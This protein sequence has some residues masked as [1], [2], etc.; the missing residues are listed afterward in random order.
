MLG[1]EPAAITEPRTA[2][3]GGRR[4]PERTPRAL[5]DEGGEEEE[6]DEID[7][8]FGGSS[9]EGTEMGA[10]RTG[11]G[12]SSVGGV[13]GAEFGVESTGF[14]A[15][16]GGAGESSPPG[17]PGSDR[18]MAGVGTGRAATAGGGAPRVIGTAEPPRGG[19]I[20]GRWPRKGGAPPR[21]GGKPPRT[22]GADIVNCQ[23]IKIK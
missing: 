4:P 9:V 16:T 11:F 7:E 22:G 10:E 5:E 20:G 13:K 3:P 12:G 2:P 17:R 21:P 15:R 1:E 6:E 18:M 19:P 8:G 14:G 23:S